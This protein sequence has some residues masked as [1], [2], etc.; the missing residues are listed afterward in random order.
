M[1]LNGSQ[2]LAA[3]GGLICIGSVFLP[4]YRTPFSK[5]SA[6]S[7]LETFGLAQV[8]L[9]LT[10]GSAL[11][12][13]Y[14]VAGGRRP[15]LPLRVGTLLMIAGFWSALIV[16]YLMLDRPRYE[17]GSF[18]TDYSLAYGIFVALAGAVIL[19]LAGERVRRIEPRWREQRREDAESNAR[20]QLPG[21]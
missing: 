15:A 12:L 3:L 19:I 5:E 14:R 7:G 1:R 2:R 6:K 20:A 17:L 18:D 16:G 10:V 11:F 4:W 21:A 9:I 8:A 13:L